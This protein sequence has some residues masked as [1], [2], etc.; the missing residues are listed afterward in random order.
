MAQEQFDIRW[1]DSGREPQCPAD[2][3]YPQGKDVGNVFPGEVTCKV[4][5]PYPAKRCGAYLVTCRKC[6]IKAGCTT[7]GRVDDPRSLTIVCRLA[8]R[9]GNA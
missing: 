6:G 1:L 5:L 7:A 8:Q 3:A 4:V 2:P 9:F